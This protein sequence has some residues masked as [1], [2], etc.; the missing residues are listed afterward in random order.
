MANQA[1]NLSVAGSTKSGGSCV[2]TQQQIEQLLK[3]LPSASSNSN[4]SSYDTDE[5][6]DYNFTEVV[7]CSYAGSASTEWIL[8]TGATYHMTSKITK[9]KAYQNA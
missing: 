6:S 4:K 8:D 7:Y 2:L 5:E 3:V 9:R 1:E